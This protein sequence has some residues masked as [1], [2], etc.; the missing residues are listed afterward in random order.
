MTSL[1]SL[2]KGPYKR[3]GTTQSAHGHVFERHLLMLFGLRGL[4]KGYEYSLATELEDADIF[5]DVV[6]HYIIEGCLYTR[7]LQAKHF[8]EQKTEITVEDLLGGKRFDLKKYFE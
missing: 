6:F 3:K 4:Q 1:P 2:P 8:D 5:D 7:L